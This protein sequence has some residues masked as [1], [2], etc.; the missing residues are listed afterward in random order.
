M[1]LMVSCELER[2]FRDVK[3]VSEDSQRKNKGCMWLAEFCR[4]RMHSYSK[5]VAS[6]KF[7]N[8]EVYPT[9]PPLPRA[10]FILWPIHSFTPSCSKV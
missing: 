3:T 1:R 6:Q 7:P 5:V 2:Q 10:N 9:R 8:A 4:R